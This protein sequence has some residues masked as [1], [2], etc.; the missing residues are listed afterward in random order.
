MKARSWAMLLITSGTALL[1]N[2]CATA[3]QVA[4]LQETAAKLVQKD[5]LNPEAWVEYGRAALFSNNLSAAEMAFR[6]ALSLN[7][8]YLPAYKHL[9][10]VLVTI[11]RFT[12]AKVNYEHALHIS[13]KDSELWTAYG[14]CLVD[15][16]NKKEAI[17]AFKK[18]IEANTNAVAV[19]SAHLGLSG[20]FRTTGDELSAKREIQEAV[21][22]IQR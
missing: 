18:S 16:G 4:P 1:F 6:R 13:E 5:P 20:I 17:E 2:G 14:Y 22:L 7:E 9:G 21:K 11:K 8:N 3:P 15:L 12:D 19:V 10:M